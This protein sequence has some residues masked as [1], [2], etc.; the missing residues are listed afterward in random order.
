MRRDF[1]I[2][3]GIY[4]IQ[5]PHELDLH[6]LFDFQELR[7]SVAERSLSLLWRRSEREGVPASLPA[8]AT[9]EFRGVTDF[10]FR[11]RDPDL[12]FTEDYCLRDSG[13]WTDEDWA[14]GSL[15]IVDEPTKADEPWLTAI[16]FM[17]GAMILVQADSAH[18][19]IAV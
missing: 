1:E 14:K 9:I 6:N 12:P 15:I 13:Y 7:Y 8:S 19:T 17:S 11:P 16:E 3:A 4:L 10:R 2:R 18:A 5:S